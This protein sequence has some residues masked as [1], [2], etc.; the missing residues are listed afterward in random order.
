M[1]QILHVDPNNIDPD[2]IQKAAE[3]LRSGRLVAFPTETV[4]G[5]GA[6]AFE[7]VAVAKI[8][9][10]KG[11]PATDPLIVHIADRGQLGEIVAEMPEIAQRV[12]DRF[13]PG[14]LTLILKRG[15]RIPLNVTANQET[16]AVRMPDHAVALA[17]IRAAG[18]PVAA[19]SANLFSRPS[20]TSAD[21][22]MQD[23][24]GRIEMVLDGGTTTLGLESTILDLTGDMPKVLR[25]GGV[26]LEA[27]REQ[28]SSIIRR[29][30]RSF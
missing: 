14:A 15:S 22:V 9:V 21:H 20:P 18:V 8:F 13:W 11:R 6:N 17:L 16:V 30:R 24:N 19:P 12:A 7:A 23:L 10:A 5:L 25:P 29:A 3:V 27:L 1:T 28:R 26:S 4:Y 2:L